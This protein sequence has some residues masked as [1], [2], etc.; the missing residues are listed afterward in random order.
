MGIRSTA[1]RFINLCATLLI[2]IAANSIAYSQVSPHKP[3]EPTKSPRKNTSKSANPRPSLKPKAKP[4]ERKPSET[5]SGTVVISVSERPAEIFL[6]DADGVSMLEDDP[7]VVAADG[8]TTL[9]VEDLNP[10]TYTL[11]VRKV[12]YRE[13]TRQI[14]IKGDGKSVSVGVRLDPLV[15]FLSTSTNI[16]GPEIEIPGVI[17]LSSDLKAHPIAPGTYSVTAKK[18]GYTSE[19]KTVTI[20]MLGSNVLVDFTIRRLQLAELLESA[21]RRFAEQ[22]YG[23]S[24]ELVSLALEVQ[25]DSPRA[26]SIMGRAMYAARRSG[27]AKHLAGAIKGGEAVSLDVRVASS[28]PR[29]VYLGQMT[30]A[31]NVVWFRTSYRPDLAF[32]LSREEIREIELKVDDQNLSYLSIKGRG[33][34]NGKSAER[35][36]AIYSDAI[37]LRSDVTFCPTVGNGGALR[38]DADA[39]N[40]E[41]LFR[42]WI[43]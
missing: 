8:P 19:T 6:T 38:C 24:I 12:N 2:L 43:R 35:R 29:A 15:A 18:F 25:A 1:V 36:I 7:Y 39:A 26:Q 9:T 14:V 28:K 22:D 23:R 5:K 33:N 21:E 3:E 37:A 27:A 30:F 42:L 41:Q 31:G 40:L 17:R 20:T 13:D 11:V 34:F 10:G 4:K 32:A 16:D